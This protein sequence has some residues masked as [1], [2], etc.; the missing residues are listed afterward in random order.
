[1]KNTYLPKEKKSNKV[2]QIKEAIW[3]VSGGFSW[4]SEGTKYEG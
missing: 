1:M 4:V 2:Y 3:E